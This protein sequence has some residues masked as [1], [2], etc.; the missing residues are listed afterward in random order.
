M[1][2]E[3]RAHGISGIEIDETIETW[4]KEGFVEKHDD[5]ISITPLG[6]DFVIKII[7]NHPDLSKR[8]LS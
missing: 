8:D 3:L 4:L 7:T 5:K 2:K 6:E 1:K